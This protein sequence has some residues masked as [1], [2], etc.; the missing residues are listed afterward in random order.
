[1]GGERLPGPGQEPDPQIQI[2]EE[3]IQTMGGHPAAPT[4][5]TPA[6]AELQ[7]APAAPEFVAF[8]D[9]S[10]LRYTAEVGRIMDF[11]YQQVL[12]KPED[13]H[14]EDPAPLL[15]GMV[16]NGELIAAAALEPR[17][18][19]TYTLCLFAVVDGRRNDGLG[20]AFL[21]QV[22][23]WAASELKAKEIVVLPLELELEPDEPGKTSRT[24]YENRDYE[25]HPDEEDMLRKQL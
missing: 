10:D 5:A 23:E 14:P 12:D 7:D 13:T 20:T 15:Y 1:M 16:E 24:F 22:E 9:L 11:L 25:Q 4:E 8:N 18:P 19:N 21:T 2:I 3:L 17:E 6:D